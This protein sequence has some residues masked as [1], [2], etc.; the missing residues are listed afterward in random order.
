MRESRER[1]RKNLTIYQNDRDLK[2]TKTIQNTLK[3]TKKMTIFQWRFLANR[4]LRNLMWKVILDFSLKPIQRK[5]KPREVNL[6]VE[7][8]ED[9]TTRMTEKTTTEM[10][11]VIERAQEELRRRK[12]YEESKR[13]KL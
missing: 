1:R 7:I 11:G 5:A 13:R 9:E 3:S 10:T 6:I 8:E 2:P 4:D 12:V